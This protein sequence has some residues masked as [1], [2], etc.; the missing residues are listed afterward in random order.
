MAKLALNKGLVDNLMTRVQV[1]KYLADQFPDEKNDWK[2]IHY[3]DYEQNSP[4]KNKNIIGVVSIAG[5][6]LDGSQPKGSAGG[7]NISAMIKE[8]RNEKN[9]KALVLRVNT[10]GGSAFASEI[11]REQVLAIKDR[12]IPI[13]VSMGGLAA[14]GGYWI[15]ADSDYIFA[16]ESSVTGSIGVAAILFDAQETIKKI[17]LNEDGVSNSPFA[18]SLNNGILLSSPSEEVVDLI[19]GNVDRLYNDFI[20]IVANGRGISIKEAD[21]IAKGRVWSGKDA[22]EVGLIDQIGSFDDAVD[23]AKD[24]AAIKD[25]Y[26]KEYDKTKNN[27][28]LII[29]FLNLFLFKSDFDMRDNLYANLKNEF[30]SIFKW[31]KNLND[32]NQLYYICEECTIIN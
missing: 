13:V 20:E 17:G 28:S 27:I 18:G 32:R 10:P 2:F 30:I 29:E 11:I 1:E 21:L 31:S 5:T 12:D 8:A 26:L 22:L 19:Q 25:Y 23:K 14:S 7:E 15:S 4:E 3:R 16:H 6:I 24:L 9:L